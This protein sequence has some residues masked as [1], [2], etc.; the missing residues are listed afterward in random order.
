MEISEIRSQIEPIDD[1]LLK[2]FLERMDLVDEVTKYKSEHHMP[3]NDMSREREILSRITQ[4]AG[5]KEMYVHHFFTNLF[6]LSKARQR[7]QIASA[8]NLRKTI[9]D[10]VANGGDLF[11]KSGSVACQGIEGSN[12]QAAAEKMIPRGNITHVKNFEAV[13]DAVGNGLCK[14]GVLPI[15]NSSNGSVRGV[16]ELLQNH[17]DYII[18][19]TKLF[20]RHELLAKPGVS[21]G[22][23]RTI[24][25]HEQA[26]GQCSKF[27]TSLGEDVTII[28]CSNTAVAA[29]KV[30]ESNDP[31][32]AAISSHSCTEIY[33]LKT[34]CNTIQN[35]DNNYTRFI[36]I[37]KE[38]QIFAGAN[39]ISLVINCNNK[40][41]ALYDLLA[42]LAIMDIN[43]N[44]LE[45]CPVVGSD[46]EFSFFL[47]IDASVKEPG[48]ISL[49]E[50]LERICEQF[51]F[52]GN[53]MEV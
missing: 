36:C 17:N 46:F 25:S 1:Q 50:E 27:L 45:S 14:Y 30:A 37:S 15:E 51:T 19:S 52:L 47:D 5:D 49:L 3:I 43:M 6:Q 13:F 4:N 24:Y 42:K 20:I 40:P 21:L 11:P 7:E 10:A 28:P 32:V 33:G 38:P 8:S 9:E 29:K 18:G 16:Y 12:S 31:T 39:R 41:G 34:L 23:I 53:Y 2:L 35:S 26:I 44:K 22:D 48:L